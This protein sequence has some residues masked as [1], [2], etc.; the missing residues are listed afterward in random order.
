[1]AQPAIDTARDHSMESD[2]QSVKLDILGR[3]MLSN[4]M[5]FACQVKSMSPGSMSVAAAVAGQHNER[6]ILYLDHIGRIDGRIASVYA[7]GFDISFKAAETKK[8]RLAA[9]LT[10]LA[11]R[12]ELNLPEDRRHDRIMPK[13]PVIS[14][15]MDDGR[16]YSARIT[17]MSLSGA[18]MDMDVRPAIGSRV[19]LG[20]MPA[21]VVRHSA[22]GIAV[23]FSNVQRRD[24]LEAFLHG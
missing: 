23:E 5:E 11:N 9:K 16:S 2:F 15:H 8:D 6:V 17:D 18:A 3:Y 14:V 20:K 22:E 1:M 7:G 13:D 21:R 4:R 10:W 24:T 19:Q 12:H